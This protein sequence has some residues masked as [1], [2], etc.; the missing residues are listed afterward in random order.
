MSLQEGLCV[1]KKITN[2]THYDLVPPRIKQFM[3]DMKY[4]RIRS[5][6]F[7][8]WEG[9]NNAFPIGKFKEQLSQYVNPSIPK[10]KP[11]ILLGAFSKK[12]AYV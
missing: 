5:H 4:P 10:I 7:T 8:G 2:E 6:G 9:I 11:K 3:F 1:S 12:F